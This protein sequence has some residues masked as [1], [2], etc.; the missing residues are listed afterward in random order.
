VAII[1]VL[2]SSCAMF[3][4]KGYESQDL[5]AD[6]AAVIE[7][8]FFIHINKC[9][10]V[11]LG[12]FQNKVIILPGEHTIEMSFQTQTTGDLIS[13]SN[14]TASLTFKTEAGHTYVAHGHR[15][16]AEGWIAYVMD[17]KTGERVA[18][19][20]ILPIIEEWINERPE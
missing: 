6:K 1:S 16:S 2:A 18:Q 20:E 7:N 10:G 14:E 11:D 9:D 5:S 3:T 12:F 13:Y 4:M 17:K 15:M 19:S 8:G